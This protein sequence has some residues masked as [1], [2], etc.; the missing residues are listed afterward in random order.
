MSCRITKNM[1]QLT[2]EYSL[3]LSGIVIRNH[4]ERRSFLYFSEDIG[5]FGLK[6][7]RVEKQKG[8]LNCDYN[9]SRV[10]DPRTHA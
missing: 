10:L 1:L 2:Y 5:L 8:R 9:L 3:N 6:V 7:V 4:L